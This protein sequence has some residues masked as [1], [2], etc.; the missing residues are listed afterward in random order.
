MGCLKL[1]AAGGRSLSPSNFPFVMP[2]AAG[3]RHADRYPRTLPNAGSARAAG[4]ARVWLCA[5]LVS[6]VRLENRRS[7]ALWKR[8]A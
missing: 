5:A 3:V 6:G 8:D 1:P 2:K 7:V 4:F